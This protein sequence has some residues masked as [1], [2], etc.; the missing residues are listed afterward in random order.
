[1]MNFCTNLRFFD[2]STS[3]L[4]VVPEINR[5][6]E[7]LLDESLFFNV[8]DQTK[9]EVHLRQGICMR[10][11]NCK[12]MTLNNPPR[13][14]NRNDLF[15]LSPLIQSSNPTAAM[16][17]LSPIFHFYILSPSGYQNPLQIFSNFY[18]PW[19]VFYFLYFSWRRNPR[20]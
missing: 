4:P 12:T 6:V 10:N 15:W 5:F 1:M 9:T 14:Y 11:W 8:E 7:V 13:N 16:K 18:S 17:K 2:C 3:K 20:R 19:I